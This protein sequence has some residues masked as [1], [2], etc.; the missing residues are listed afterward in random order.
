[1]SIL[2]ERP[3]SPQSLSLSHS[4]R[5]VAH[6]SITVCKALLQL[7]VAAIVVCSLALGMS[8]F[9]PA[10]SQPAAVHGML[11][12]VVAPASVCSALMIGC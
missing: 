7:V 10:V 5:G 12:Q 4:F 1:M 11:A 9:H 8:I 3:I 6:S 2:P